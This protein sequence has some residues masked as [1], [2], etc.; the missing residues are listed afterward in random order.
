[1]IAEF[2]IG[3]REALE[4]ALIIGII[5]GYLKKTNQTEHNNRVYVGIA[6]GAIASIF[7]AIAFNFLSI[8]FEGAAEAMFEGAVMVVAA[9]VLTWMIFWM[10]KQKQIAQNIQKAVDKSLAGGLTALAFIA[11]YREGFETVLFLNALAFSSNANPLVGAFLGM[12]AAVVLGFFLYEIGIR[13]DIKVF[14]RITSVMLI[15]FAAGLVAH[16]FHEFQEAGAIT[17]FTDEA[18]NTKWVLDDKSAVGAVAR[19]LLGYNDNP[20]WLEVFAYAFYLTVMLYFIEKLAETRL[21]RRM[22]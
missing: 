1:M 12:A 4:A 13:L 5:L 2:T 8:Q 14:F 9:V 11:V 21:S 19:S 17:F 18:W 3:F 15:L 22:V 20:S 7:T 10:G 16:G 6:A